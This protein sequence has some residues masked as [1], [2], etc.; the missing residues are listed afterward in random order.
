MQ[1]LMFLRV[2]EGYQSVI[3]CCLELEIASTEQNV[4]IIKEAAVIIECLQK[5]FNML[6]TLFNALDNRFKKALI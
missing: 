5:F 6:N 2:R 1:S 4:L 3:L